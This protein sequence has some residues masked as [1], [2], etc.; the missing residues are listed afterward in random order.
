MR[1]PEWG[2]PGWGGA[3]RSEG[4]DIVLA[5]WFWPRHQGRCVRVQVLVP[6]AGQP[7]CARRGRRPDALFFFFFFYRL[8]GGLKGLTWAAR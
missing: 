5:S 4:T 2:G 8:K 7:A 3:C 1:A 6:N